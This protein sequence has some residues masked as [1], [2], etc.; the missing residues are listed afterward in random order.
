MKADVTVWGGG[1]LVTLQDAE[2][3]PGLWV[4]CM[5]V[6][7]MD[8]ELPAGKLPSLRGCDFLV[9]SPSWG[10]W[11]PAVGEKVSLSAVVQGRDGVQCD[12]GQ[13]YVQFA[14]PRGGGWRLWIASAGV[15]SIET[16]QG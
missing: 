13:G 9:E 12:I 10:G 7:G 1:R 5:D 8:G 3:D 15:C 11:V 4:E 16:V 14:V 2:Y 6:I